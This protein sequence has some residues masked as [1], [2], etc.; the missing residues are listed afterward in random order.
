MSETDTQI[1][2]AEIGALLRSAREASGASIDDIAGILRIRSDHLQALEDDDFERLPGSV[3]AIGFIRTYATHLG[4]NAAELIDR[5][6]AATTLPHLDEPSYDP[7]SE[8]D[9]TSNAVKIAVVLGVVFVVYL[10]WLIAGGAREDEVQV[11]APVAVEAPEAA[12]PA[13]KPVSPPPARQAPPK[14][15]APA[16]APVAKAPAAAPQAE[17]PQVD[18]KPLAAP[19]VNDTAAVLPEADP[20]ATDPVVEVNAMADLKPAAERKVEIR[21]TRRTWMRIE[22][23]DGKV[24]FSSIIRGDESFTLEETT[25]YTLATR[26]AGALEFVVDGEAV[27]TVGRRGQILTAREVGRDAILALQN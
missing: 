3:Y 16:K 6:K 25:P 14:P 4:L 9:A 15:K 10:M 19:S 17:P 1:E 20:L 8:V 11:A 7:Q 26:D 24:L 13:A 27:G 21:A 22:N 23:R 18:V 5:Y 2:Q 12:K